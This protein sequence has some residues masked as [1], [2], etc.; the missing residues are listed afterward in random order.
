MTISISEDVCKKNGLNPDEI[1]AILL[2]KTGTDISQLFN[3]LL[4]RHILVKDVFG[5]YLVTQRWDD[6]ASTILL[7]SDKDKQSPERLE[8]LASKLMEI[9]PKEKKAG[10]C[11]YFRGNKKDNILRLKKFFKLYGHYSD[12]QILDAA[13]RYVSSFNGNYAYMR[14]LKYFIWKDAVKRDSEGNGYVDE[15]SDL[16]NWI[17]NAGQVD[18]T[19]SDWTTNLN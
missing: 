5:S 19:N 17:E 6:V 16:A 9:F 14:I 3:S 12:E 15:T 11:H 2:V 13:R 8:K 18:S 7:D 1:L 10:T 4:E